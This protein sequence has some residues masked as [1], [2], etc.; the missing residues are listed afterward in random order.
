MLVRGICVIDFQ[1]EKQD[2]RLGDDVGHVVQKGNVHVYTYPCSA[3][4]AT[5]L[6][7]RLP[8]C[9]DPTTAT[10]PRGLGT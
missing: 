3:S 4:P 2:L 5:V 6:T 8:Y 1:A 10:I 7:T 9:E